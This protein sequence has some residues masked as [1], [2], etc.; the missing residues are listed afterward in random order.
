[1]EPF[2]YMTKNSRQKYKYLEIKKSF[3]LSVAKNCL[4]GESTPVTEIQYLQIE[5]CEREHIPMKIICLKFFFCTDLSDEQSAFCKPLLLN[6]IK[7]TDQRNV[8]F[9]LC[10]K[11]P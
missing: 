10:N 3:C 11:R 6:K 2:F 8:E 9:F 1:M 4:R 7:T 5:P